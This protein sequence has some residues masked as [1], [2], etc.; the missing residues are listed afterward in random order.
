MRSSTFTVDARSYAY[1]TG[2]MAAIFLGLY[3]CTA[4][5]LNSPTRALVD[6]PAIDD[7]ACIEQRTDGRSDK[8]PPA[9]SDW[10]RIIDGR[11]PVVISAPHATM[12][13]RD[14]KYRFS[15]GGGTAA[16][17]IELGALTAAHVIFTTYR[18]PSDPNYYDDNDYKRA[19]AKL[20]V[21]SQA[22]IL[23][24]IHG[25]SPK[26]PYDV[27]IGTMDGASL[28]GHDAWADQL[29]IV[30]RKNGLIAISNNFFSAAKNQ[31][32]TKFAA[33]HQVP[34]LQLEINAT[35]LLPAE[36]DLGAH[37]F[38]QL[39]ESLDEFIVAEE[40]STTPPVAVAFAPSCKAD[41]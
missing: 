16:L 27:D 28:L 31:T 22:R 30:L 12:P 5:P 38:A 9:G 39:L 4:L 41:F 21:T 2:C 8:D 6:L 24:D 26:R 25:S 36:S 35:W 29:E 37:R 1:I 34:A 11:I 7:G 20:L 17:A 13:F 18:S 32:V 15:D 23:L 19:L 10:Y 40:K 33:A 14:G 3:G